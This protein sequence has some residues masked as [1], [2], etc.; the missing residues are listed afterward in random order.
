MFKKAKPTFLS[1]AGRNGAPSA[2]MPFAI[3]NNKRTA[4]T[5]AASTSKKTSRGPI[6][7]ARVVKNGAPLKTTKVKP[8]VNAKT[9]K[10]ANFALKGKPS[11]DQRLSNYFM[12]HSPKLTSVTNSPQTAPQAFKPR[13]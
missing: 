3:P 11:I 1:K 10:G 2:R 7:K 4:K 9:G 5:R 6:G 13:G 12:S 8:N